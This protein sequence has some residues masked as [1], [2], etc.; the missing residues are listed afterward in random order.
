M[1]TSSHRP[2]EQVGK[3]QFGVV[4]MTIHDSRVAQ[5]ERTATAV[6]STRRELGGDDNAFPVYES[7]TASTTKVFSSEVGPNRYLSKNAKV[8]LNRDQTDFQGGA[9]DLIAKGK[10]AIFTRTQISF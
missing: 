7:P 9:T 5:I 10:K 3:L 4:Q 8:N 1:R 6:I 2:V